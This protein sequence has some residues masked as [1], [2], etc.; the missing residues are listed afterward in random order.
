MHHE[1][2][3]MTTENAFI[4][5]LQMPKTDGKEIAPGVFLIGEPTPQPHLGDNRMTCLA[6]IYGALCVVELSIRLMPKNQ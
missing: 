2:N 4:G 5:Q 1:R 6:D 3:T